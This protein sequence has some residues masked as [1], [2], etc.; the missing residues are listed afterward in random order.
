MLTALAGRKV[1]EIDFV[2]IDTET[3]GLSPR[4]GGEL[5]ELAGVRARGGEIV[6]R[7]Q[8]LIRP[9]RP[10]PAHV[11]RI[12]GITDRMVA[13]APSAEAVLREFLPF[14]EGAVWGFHNA[15]FDMSFIIAA[16]QAAQIDLPDAP[17]FD[18][19]P[20]SRKLYPN[21]S[22][23]LPALVERF[24][25]EQTRAHRALSDAEATQQLFAVFLRA[26]W[27][28]E[29]PLFADICEYALFSTVA[30]VCAMAAR[31]VEP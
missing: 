9:I 1:G 15:R 28:G 21:M 17:I 22:H 14:A 6:D 20:M 10:I 18:T 4:A 11:T 27:T 8:K 3:T 31:R 13:N 19:L 25:V 23:A 5:V 16:A 30:K 26:N 24:A 7:F 12:H 29:E 2:F